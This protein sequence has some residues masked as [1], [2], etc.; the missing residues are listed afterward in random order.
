MPV[1]MKPPNSNLVTLA[2]SR[3]R[4]CTT[5]RSIRLWAPPPPALLSIPVLLRKYASLPMGLADASRVLLAGACCWKS[6]D[7]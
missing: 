3:A 6:R 7:V 5:L 2:G 4:A 1:S